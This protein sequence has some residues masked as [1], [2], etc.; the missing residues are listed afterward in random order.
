MNASRWD[1]W[2]NT[3]AVFIAHVFLDCVAEDF[4]RKGRGVPGLEKAVKFTELGRPLGLGVCGFHT[5]LQKNR[6]PFESIETYAFNNELFTHLH[7]ETL[8]AS[9]W[10]AKEFGEPEW[11]KGYGVR[12]THRTAE[13]PTKSSALLMAG[14]SEGI[15]PDVAMTFTQLTPAGEMDRA[16]PVLLELM[17]ERGVYDDAHMKELTDAQGSVQNVDW[18]TP[19]EKE[20]FK[21]AFEINQKFILKLAAARQRKLCQGQSLN[22]FF[23]ADEDEE[24]IAEVHSEA[25]KDPLILG[26]YYCY[27]KAGVTASKGECA[28]CQ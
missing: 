12:N 23:S 19:E 9:Q 7:D 5:Y 16:N 2:K 25:F 22:L 11:C 14:I 8:K 13:A 6:I 20:V 10:L 1:Q 17:K 15:N 28:S 26:L 18:L 27:S 24:Y 3:K 21:T 4:I